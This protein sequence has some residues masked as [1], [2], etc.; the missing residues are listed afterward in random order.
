MPG[1]GTSV[2]KHLK[3]GCGAQEPL[4]PAAGSKMPTQDPWVT[5]RGP[6]GVL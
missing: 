4:Q 3:C 6:V 1:D 5:R 2:P